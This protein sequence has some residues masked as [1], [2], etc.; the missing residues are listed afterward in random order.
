[1]IY[2]TNWDEP[3]AGAPLE[4]LACGT[5]IISTKN[6]CM[7]EMVSDGKTGVTCH[8][9]SELL[10]APK[11][12]NSVR[13]EDCR[14]AVE[15][16]FSVSRMAADYLKLFERILKTGKLVDGD[17]LPRYNFKK[18]NVKFLYKPTLMNQ[19]RLLMTGKV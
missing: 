7:P 15:T 10:E 5:P 11:K 4:A 8:S 2:P 3:C 17:H 18:E 16:Y 14:Q 13:P 1:L 6:G 19:A 12:L 9:Y